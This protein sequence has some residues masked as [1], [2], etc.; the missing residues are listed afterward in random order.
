MA[1][2]SNQP[3]FR[4]ELLCWSVFLT[5]RAGRRSHAILQA[6]LPKK[7]EYV[8]LLRMTALQR[9]LY[10]SYML[11]LTSRSGHTPNPLR[12]FVV[13]CKV[14][15][16]GRSRE[17]ARAGAGVEGLQGPVW[18]PRLGGWWGLQSW[19]WGGSRSRGRGGAGVEA[20]VG[21]VVGVTVGA[22]VV[23]MGR[24]RCGDCGREGDEMFH[25]IM[26]LKLVLTET[27]KK[28][29]GMCLATKGFRKIPSVT[30]YYSHLIAISVK[31]SRALCFNLF[32]WC[33]L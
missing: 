20:T 31:I 24:G 23:V 16:A 5:C 32:V 15:R 17:G 26:E 30:I 7:E 25:V 19:L 1:W 13:S 11:D 12:A 22:A 14:G 3:G 27:A 9:R 10:R 33:F 21:R 29:G 4:D 6:T 18:R 8:C 2:V 28:W